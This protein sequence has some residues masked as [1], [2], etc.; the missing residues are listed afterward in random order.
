MAPWKVKGVE[1]RYFGGMSEEETAEVMKTSPRTVSRDW[2][3]ARAWLMRQL[4]RSGR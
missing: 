2:Q 4:S 1:L 3:F